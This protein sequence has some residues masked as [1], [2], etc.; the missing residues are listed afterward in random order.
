MCPHDLF[1]FNIGVAMPCPRETVILRGDIGLPG[2][3]GPKGR[4]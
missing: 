1:C 4:L 3:E 2:P